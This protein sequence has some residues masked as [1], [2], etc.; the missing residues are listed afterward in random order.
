MIGNLIST[1]K[2]AGEVGEFVAIF[3]C[4]GGCDT[5]E[6]G[7]NVSVIPLITEKKVG[8]FRK[9]ARML[10]PWRLRIASEYGKKRLGKLCLAPTGCRHY[11][12]IHAKLYCPLAQ[13][14]QMLRLV[15]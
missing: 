15:F 4:I 6:I 1:T 3:Q 10:F 8:V 5:R 13:K 14:L 12:G 2:L 7:G 11:R 9:R